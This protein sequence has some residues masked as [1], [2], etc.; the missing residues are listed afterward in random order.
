MRTGKVTA[1]AVGAAALAVGVVA[2]VA[3]AGSAAIKSSATAPSQANC[4]KYGFYHCLTPGQV[5]DAYNLPP[6]YTRGVTGKGQTIVI[7]D[8]FGSPTIK[9]DLTVFDQQFK[10]PAPP[11][12]TIITPSG[13][14]PAWNSS[15]SDMTGWGG[16]T[17]LDVEYAHSVA[18]GA[19]ILLVET[20]V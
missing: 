19:N 3:P 1:M 18:P 11:S 10:L 14:I 12:F 4:V 2:A 5:E 20:P 9:H 8:S 15:D 7:V 13:K 6:L 17:T 16:E